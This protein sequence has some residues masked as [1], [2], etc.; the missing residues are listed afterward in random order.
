MALHTTWQIEEIEYLGMKQH[1]HEGGIA[2][3]E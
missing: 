1:P 3:V 2:M